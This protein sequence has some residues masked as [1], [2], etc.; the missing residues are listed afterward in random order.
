MKGQM[1]AVVYRGPGRVGI[2]VVP[3][4]DLGP[5]DLLLRVRAASVCATDH[6][7]VAHG[8]FKIP[9]ETSRILGHEFVGEVVAANDAY[10]GLSPGTRVVVAPNLGCG[11]CR[12]CIQGLDN[13]CPH[14]EALGITV[15][16]AL[17]RYVR[18]PADFVRRGHVVALPDDLGDRQA[19]LI[20][21]L[22]TV[23][24]AHEAVATRLGD[25]V[26]VVGAGPMGLMHVLVAR[27]AGAAAVAV[28]EPIESRRVMALSLGAD[29]A[30][31]PGESEEA[32]ANL[33]GGDGFDV[34]VVAVPVRDAQ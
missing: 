18:V 20:E 12:A 4:P 5:G 24:A 27:A 26:V 10:P 33:T 11:R 16:G 22:S 7:I 19:A 1:K 34:V 3:V 31:E 13:L 17:A 30:V 29:M 8:H 2:E 28:I 6:K 21:P 15:D 23:V 25:R 14:Y 9:S 32:I